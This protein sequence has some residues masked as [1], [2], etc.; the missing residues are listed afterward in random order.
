MRTLLQVSYVRISILTTLFF[1]F[2]S[3][4]SVSAPPNG[5]GGT[6]NV[7][8]GAAPNGTGAS[9]GNGASS[10]DGASSGVGGSS[11]GAEGGTGAG[12]GTCE[13]GVPTTSQI[14]RLK[15]SEYDNV[16]RDLLGVTGL[17]SEGGEPPSSLLNTDSTGAMNSYMWDAYL[18]AAEAIAAQ[19]MAG[20]NRSNFISCDPAETGCLTETIETFGRK[21]FRRPLTDEE[22]ARFE[23]LGNTDP[24]GTPEEV[25]ETTLIA[26]L[27]SPSFLQVNELNE[28]MEGSY[29]KL[30][31]HEV[32]TRLSLM[33][34]GSIPDDTL[35][36]AADAGELQT[37]EQILAQAERM[38]AERDKAG[39]RLAEFHMHY[40]GVD[41]GNSRWFQTIQDSEKF[42]LYSEEALPAMKAELQAFFEDVAYTGTFE[43]LFLSNVGYVNED[44][45]ALYGLD[46]ANFGPE[47]ERVELDAERRPGFLTRLAFLSSYSH[48]GNTSPILRG[49][50]LTKNIIGSDQELIPDEDALKATVEG[51]Y[52]T[53]RAYVTALTDK[54]ACKGCHHVYI[55]PPGFVLEN[56]DA[57]GS[58]QTTDP[59]GGEIDATAEVRFADGAKEI[60]SARQ[61]MEEIAGGDFARRNYVQGMVAAATGRFPNANDACLVDELDLK[62]TEDGYSIL[63][64][65]ADI[66]QADSFRLRNRAAN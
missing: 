62:L 49:A 13:P 2:L 21:A 29:Y 58:W 8:T 40:V 48:S 19:V 6:N 64:L 28:E 56:Y 22:V 30:S 34:W 12:P 63:D 55:N 27:V 35:N 36:A 45:A 39:E 16:V 7:G 57:V 1:G 53:E 20:E 10:G 14:P 15:N 33:I 5:N 52:E 65:V 17:E 54:P 9:S 32:A 46:P 41:G 18:N 44:T 51:E 3:G 47:V 66:T 61:M 31:N 43:D 4:C 26:F 59:R 50:F 24:P 23:N 60:T 11:G 37:K 38:I 25:A 42:P